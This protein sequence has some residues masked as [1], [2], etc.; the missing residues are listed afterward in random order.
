MDTN[1]NEKQ[2]TM[3][4]G[5]QP[6][7]VASQSSLLDSYLQDCQQQPSSPA[8]SSTSQTTGDTTFEP[9]IDMMVNDFDDEQTLTEEEALAELEAQDP[10]DEI[11]TLQKESEIPLEKLLAHYRQ[12]VEQDYQQRRH[13]R[14]KS[15]KKDKLS[16]S[17]KQLKSAASGPETEACSSKSH[18]STSNVNTNSTALPKID[19]II[20]I[21]ESEDEVEILKTEQ[22]D[23]DAAEDG[24]SLQANEIEE[25]NVD[26]EDDDDD[27][28]E[29]EFNDCSDYDNN[30]EDR[31]PEHSKL[32]A[33]A[34]LYPDKYANIQEKMDDGKL[35][36]VYYA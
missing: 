1:K 16:R 26:E 21:E 5:K 10:A 35:V 32:T 23:I 30:A 18:R 8:S 11:E 27:E 31:P 28:E 9:S 24:S 33:L 15:S 7:I 36:S 19:E 6:T 3:G 34:L 4:G 12:H 14:K 2:S 13:K 17:S 22:T 29:A 20:V 25:V